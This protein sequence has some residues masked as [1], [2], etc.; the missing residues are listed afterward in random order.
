VGGQAHGNLLSCCGSE[1][2]NLVVKG[3]CECADV[4]HG[5]SVLHVAN[6]QQSLHGTVVWHCWM[7]SA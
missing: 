4:F 5:V 6:I 3:L 7:L 1:K 2:D